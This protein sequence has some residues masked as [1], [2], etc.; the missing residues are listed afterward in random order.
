MIFFLPR[1]CLSYCLD[2]DQ[3]DQGASSRFRFLCWKGMWLV[4]SINVALVPIDGVCQREG[5]KVWESNTQGRKWTPDFRLPVYR[6]QIQYS[7]GVWL[8][9]AA[10]P[11][12][13]CVWTLGSPLLVLFGKTEEHLGGG[14]LLEE[15]VTGNQDLAV[16]WVGI[17]SCWL[18]ASWLL[19]QCDK[20]AAQLP[21]HGVSRSPR[22]GKWKQFLTL[23]NWF[24]LRFCYSNRKGS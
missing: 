3:G 16:S 22:D 17:T 4:S 14:A 23:S 15:V 10:H 20:L 6:M 21:C 19:R 13:A 24:V 5:H 8:C 9:N 18:S 2:V 12:G 11:I 7:I 1:S